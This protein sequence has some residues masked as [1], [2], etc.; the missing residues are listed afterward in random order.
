MRGCR[1]G[2]GGCAHASDGLGCQ[3]RWALPQPA[4]S[5]NKIIK[6]AG[7]P[8]HGAC[9]MIRSSCGVVCGV[10]VVGLWLVPARVGHDLVISVRDKYGAA[11]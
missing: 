4:A 2:A 6:A 8:L 5:A 9:A 11:I 10:S 7:T 1:A 3:G